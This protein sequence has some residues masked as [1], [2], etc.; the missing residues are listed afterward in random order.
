MG[1]S[2]DNSVFESS[3]FYLPNGSEFVLPLI[4]R[5]KLLC[6]FTLHLRSYKCFVRQDEGAQVLKV[7]RL[8]VAQKNEV[9]PESLAFS[10]IGL[11]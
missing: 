7:W 4:K 2:S 3:Q 6:T 1:A 10:S 8:N 9:I 11:G 5:C